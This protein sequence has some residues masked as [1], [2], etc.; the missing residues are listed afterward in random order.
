M[1][2]RYRFSAKKVFSARHPFP[3]YTLGM[4]NGRT[5][6]VNSP[7]LITAIQRAPKSFSFDPIITSISERLSVPSKHGIDAVRYQPHGDNG[8]RGITHDTISAMRTTLSPGAILD[9]MNEKMLANVSAMLD[10]LDCAEGMVT[11]L[12]EWARHIITR[13][14]TNA[15]FG[16]LNPF[17]PPEIEEAFW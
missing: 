15:F 12:F 5:Y 1:G 11:N 17:K 6:I 13:A 3:I 4:L 16:P 9:E 7:D 2:L 14:S 8:E 10:G